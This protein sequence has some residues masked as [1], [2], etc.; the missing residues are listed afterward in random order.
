M[1][2]NIDINNLIISELST[3]KQKETVLKS[4]FKVKAYT[5]TIKIIKEEFQDKPIVEGSELSSY[6]GVGPKIIAKIDEIIKNG[7][8]EAATKV[9]ENP[10]IKLINDFKDGIYGIGV[11]KATELVKKLNIKTI[12]E[13]SEKQ[14][15]KMENGRS[16][17]NTVQKKGLK[18]YKECLLKIPRSEMVVHDNLINEICKN[19]D[20]KITVTISGSY[21][22]KLDYSGDID[23]LIKHESDDPKIFKRFVFELQ[24]KGYIIEDF[25]YGNKKFH[26]MCKLEGYENA[27]RIDVLFTT[28]EEY[29][30]ALFYFTGSGSFNPKLRQIVMGKGYKLS[31]QGIYEIDI[32]TKK[33]L[34]KIEKTN[35]GEIFKTEED[36]FDFINI[37]YISP[38]KRNP[39][40]LD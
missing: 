35:K 22:R 34:N 14:D 17:L 32:S 9:R 12:E 29:P 24:N 40:I 20:N 33:V 27:R 36:I 15:D 4:W 2:K 5:N 3:L 30:F 18:Y 19:L 13:L 28:V 7:S 1:S 37:P 16:L 8:L 6:K 21:R 11:T 10:E 25:V 38:D 39:N 23:V 26:G 31:E